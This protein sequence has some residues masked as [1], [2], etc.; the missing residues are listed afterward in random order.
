MDVG[1]VSRSVLTVRAGTEVNEMFVV[2]SVAP[3]VPSGRNEVFGRCDGLLVCC[4]RLRSVRRLPE[5][6]RK[7]CVLCVLL[8]SCFGRRSVGT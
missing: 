2:L 4:V 8:V 6:Q 1:G 5:T 7:V 3:D